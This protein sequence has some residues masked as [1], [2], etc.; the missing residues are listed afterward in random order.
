MLLFSLFNDPAP[1]SQTGH[2]KLQ[3]F[4]GSIV[5]CTGRPRHLSDID[6]AENKSSR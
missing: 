2:L 4:V 3:V 6:N 1:V 5:K